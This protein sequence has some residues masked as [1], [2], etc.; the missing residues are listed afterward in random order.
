MKK[1]PKAEAISKIQSQITQIADLKT[2]R[3]DCP[4]FT[5][6]LRATDLALR[7]IFGEKARNVDEF[8]SVSYSPVMVVMGG[9]DQ[10]QQPYLSGLDEAQALLESMVDEIEE[11]WNEGDSPVEQ[12]PSGDTGN[13]ST[14]S[15][16]VF[17]V[18][19]HDDGTKETIARFVAELGFEPIILHEQASAGKTVIEKFE[20]HSE[21]CFA[22][23]LLTPDDVGGI[24]GADDL[25]PRA[26]Q[27]V[28][29]EFGYFVGKLSRKRVCALTKGD[30]EIP[31]D[32]AGVVY[33]PIDSAGAWRMLLVREMKGAGLTVDA[34][35]AI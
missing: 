17:I 31:S 12:I 7:N 5:K 29:F 13:T 3:H 6:W 1:P 21:A 8:N 33:V 34:N 9:G 32:Y 24:A 35:K 23:A 30:V 15:K 26:R 25:R 18:H 10:F 2:K 20:S 4:E 16:R 27:N 19:G 22:I 14:G 11:Y 28:I